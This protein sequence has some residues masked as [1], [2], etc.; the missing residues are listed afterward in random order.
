MISAKDQFSARKLISQVADFFREIQYTYVATNWFPLHAPQLGE[1]PTFP[2]RCI[3]G[4]GV[5]DSSLPQP[6][7][8]WDSFCCCWFLLIRELHL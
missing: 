2:T 1:P 4:L 8:G 7:F 5:W 6:L 3:L